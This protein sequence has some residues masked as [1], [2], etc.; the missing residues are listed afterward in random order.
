MLLTQTGQIEINALNELIY[1]FYF[2]IGIPIQ[3]I[4]KYGAVLGQSMPVLFPISPIRRK[5]ALP[6]ED[7]LKTSSERKN[8]DR[9]HFINNNDDENYIYVDI[10]D[11]DNYHGILIAGP[12]LLST[13]TDTKIDQILKKYTCKFNIK[14][15]LLRYYNALPMIDI[16]RYDFISRLLHRLSKDQYTSSINIEPDKS[17]INYSPKLIDYRENSFFHVPYSLEK[18]LFDALRKGDSNKFNKISI[19]LSKY[20]RAPLSKNNPVRAMK[21]SLIIACAFFA[22]SA[23]EGGLDH[24][25]AFTL[26]DCYILKIEEKNTFSE[27]MELAE[28]INLDFLFHIKNQSRNKY[29]PIIQQSIA[30]I[31]HHLNEPLTLN[32]VA[33]E[34]NTNPSYLSALFKKEV[35]INFVTY[36][37]KQ[38]VEEAKRLMEFSSDSILDIALHLGFSTQ[39]YFTQIFKKFEGV[40]P[41][42]YLKNK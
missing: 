22:R 32:Q 23:V 16:K 31:Q 18:K 6:I 3:F 26:S 13:I 42:Q 41:K 35:D 15:E 9:P 4:D 36:I 7:I 38:K 17:S 28:I 37:N 14:Q 21:N 30:Y 10:W 39:S 8:K 5:N 29:S 20:K 34:V 40:T 25:V 24:H 1:T 19:E 11:E 33:N 12:M 27:L 2:S